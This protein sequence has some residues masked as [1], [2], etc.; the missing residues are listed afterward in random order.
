MALIVL[1]NLDDVTGPLELERFYKVNN[2][3]KR[4]LG[5]WGHMSLRT[6][7][8]ATFLLDLSNSHGH[9]QG[10]EMPQGQ[11]PCLYL[12]NL[13]LSKVSWPGSL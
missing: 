7:A 4:G 9:G 2:E 11:D 12:F 1:V 5:F 6:T 8:H 3:K 10:S 13:A